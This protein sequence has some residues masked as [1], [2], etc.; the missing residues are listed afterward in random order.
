MRILVGD[1]GGTKTLLALYEG[2][3]ARALEETRR[4]RYENASRDALGPILVDF[5]GRTEP[6]DAAV[7]GVAGPVE[8]DVC[9]ATNLPWVIDAARIA[10]ELSIPRTALINDSEA[11]ALGLDELSEESLVVL[12]D[13]RIEAMAPRAVLGAGTGLGEAIIIPTGK[14]LPRVLATEGGHVDFAPRDEDEIALLRFAL[15][16]HARVSVERVVSGPGLALIYDHVVAAKLAPPSS[17]FDAVPAS[18]DRS[19]LIGEAG[20]RG[21]DE[22]ARIALDR[23]VSLYGAEAGNLALKCL[24]FGGLYIAGGIAPKV[25]DALRAGH[26]M[27][28]FRTKGRMTPLL[29]RIRVSV[30]MDPAVGLLGARRKALSLLRT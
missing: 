14:D 11:V 17:L 2:R 26:F 23:F 1:I 3:D 13:R 22:A 5:L 30:V 7:F 15:E 4:E 12:Q 21:D 6:V 20:A 18:E 24:P 27:K 29:D 8:D 9:R 25:I 19:A 10:T 28:S 16:R